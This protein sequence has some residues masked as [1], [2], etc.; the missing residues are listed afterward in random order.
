MSSEP[1]FELEERGKRL[2]ASWWGDWDEAAAM[3]FAH[4][5]RE[6]VDRPRDAA[7]ALVVDARQMSGCKILARGALADLQNEMRDKLRN[8]VYVAS[9]PAMRGVCLWIVKVGEDPKAKVVDRIEQVED[10]LDQ[11]SS[12]VGSAQESIIRQLRKLSKEVES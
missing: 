12:R 8:S 3:S 11:D 1:G 6:F 4:R 7:P 10:C 5:I 9:T 2:V